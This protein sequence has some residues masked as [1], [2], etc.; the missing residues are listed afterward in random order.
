M[1]D[2]AVLQEARYLMRIVVADPTYLPD[3]YRIWLV[4]LGEL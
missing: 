2:I 1:C 4:E 3:A